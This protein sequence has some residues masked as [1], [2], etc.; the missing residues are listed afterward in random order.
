MT[1]AELVAHT[2]TILR[3]RVRPYLWS[4]DELIRYL[5]EAQ[6]QFA[7]RTHQLTD[8][9]SDFTFVETEQGVATYTLDP[10]IVFVAEIHHSDGIALRDR[11]R[12]T[13]RRGPTEG[14]PT[15]YSLDGQHR[16]MRLF[17][18]PDAVYTLDLL[19]A[20][21]PLIALATDED[22]PEI[23]EDYHL[24]LCDGAVYRALRNNDPDASN[25]LSA[26][27]FK[28]SFDLQVRDAKR[29]VFRLRA[30][31]NLVARNNWTGKVS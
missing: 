14:R 20:R 25:T 8:D 18:T 23:D 11:T 1:L 26:D 24:A 6:A 27:T 7:R 12:R 2:R 4:D 5:N 30:G 15:L 16:V 28:D 9:S 22:T 29:A 17:P 3:D 21:K 19:V 13:M 10:R 31:A